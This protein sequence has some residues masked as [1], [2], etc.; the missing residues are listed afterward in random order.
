MAKKIVKKKVRSVSVKPVSVKKE[1]KSVKKGNVVSPI[2]LVSEE[3]VVIPAPVLV[4]SNK[5]ETFQVVDGVPSKPLPVFDGFQVVSV[6]DSGH[7]KTQYKCEAVDRKGNH[8]IIHV[9]KNLL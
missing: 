2:K 8:V 6:L 3:M 1:K 9:P 5:K 7:T 4:V